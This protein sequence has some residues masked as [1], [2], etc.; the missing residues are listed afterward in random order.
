MQYF[1]SFKIDKIKNKVNM[2][3][4]L[5]RFFF[6]LNKIPSIALILQL[7]ETAIDLTN[8][9]IL[10]R[11]YIFDYYNAPLNKRDHSYQ[12]IKYN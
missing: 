7:F 5:F 10:F 3:N 11:K 6:Y 4:I 1:L 12:M 9:S 2:I 8:L